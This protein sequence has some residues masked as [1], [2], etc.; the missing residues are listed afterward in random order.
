MDNPNNKACYCTS[1]VAAMITE[2]KTILWAQPTAFQIKV[3][4]QTLTKAVHYLSQSYHR[5]KII[6]VCGSTTVVTRVKDLPSMAHLIT[7]NYRVP[8]IPV[9]TNRPAIPQR[10]EAP[11]SEF[12]HFPFTWRGLRRLGRARTLS[13]VY[14]C[15]WYWSECHMWDGCFSVWKRKVDVV[16]MWLG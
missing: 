8:K 11:R 3:L 4:T 13:T 1:I 6:S 15:L 12:L 9:H 10:N 7:R 5:L 2:L 14:F 16:C